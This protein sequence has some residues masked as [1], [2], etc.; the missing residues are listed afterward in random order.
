MAVFML[1]SAGAVAWLTDLPQTVVVM[2]GFSFFITSFAIG[3]GGTGW[4]IQGEVFPTPVRGRAAAIAAAVD[5]L[6]NYALIEAFPAWKN[7][8]G[9]SG[10]MVC[11]AV[12]SVAAIV[13]WPGGSRKPRADRSRTWSTSLRKRP[14]STGRR[15]R[16]ASPGRPGGCCAGS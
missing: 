3:V 9:L 6:A 11:F 10:V 15:P 12:L 2:V 4:L 7:G 13:S 8:I 16:S 1:L 14:P 5:W